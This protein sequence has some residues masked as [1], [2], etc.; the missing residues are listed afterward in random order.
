[1][2]VALVSETSQGAYT[3]IT[4]E[5]H[6]TLDSFTNHACFDVASLNHNRLLLS[7]TSRYA[8]DDH[9]DVFGINFCRKLPSRAEAKEFWEN[10]PQALGLAR[11][12]G[13]LA[14][15]AHS[16]EDYQFKK[17]VYSDFFHSA[18][19]ASNKTGFVLIVPHCGDIKYAPDCIK[20]TP[21][22]DIDKWSAGVA[23]L[24]LKKLSQAEPRKKII[25]FI[26]TSSDHI[27]SVPAVVDVGDM[28]FGSQY[29]SIANDLNVRFSG[30]MQNHLKDYA[31][32]VY[33][34]TADKFF[35]IRSRKGTLDLAI[36]DRESSS[37]ALRKNLERLSQF[38]LSLETF[39]A[40]KIVEGMMRGRIPKPGVCLNHM[41]SGRKVAALMGLP[42]R[43]KTGAIDHCIQ[44]E[45]SEIYLKNDPELIAEIIATFL[46]SLNGA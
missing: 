2:P 30:A 40:D 20:P 17:V 42:F 5:F 37:F 16:V 39:S 13:N 41:F 24:C 10:L 8:G 29:Q 9:E 32:S 11:F 34:N 21:R 22:N 46:I 27:K 6:G 19:E 4:V 23:A 18:F 3:G 15:A 45:C 33:N 38:G 36:N 28:G 25:V 43:M 7:K 35:E 26:H 14:F 12:S 1:M 44:F 31:N